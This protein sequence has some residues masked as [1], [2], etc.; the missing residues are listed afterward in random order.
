MAETEE[1]AH[2]PLYDW[3]AAN[4]AKFVPFAGYNM[5]VQYTLGVMKEHLWTRTEAGLFDVS[6]MG[7]VRL[8]GPDHETLAQFLEGLTPTDLQ[9]LEAGRQRYCLLLNDAGGIIDDLMVARPRLRP[10]TSTGGGELLLV[11]NAGRKAVDIAHLNQHLPANCKLDVL[12]HGL[13]ALQGPRTPD[14]LAGLVPAA[15]E[16]RFMDAAWFNADG[17]EVHITRSGYTGE[18]GFEILCAARDAPG[19]W[20][21]LISDDRVEAIG[22]GARDSL[23]MEAGMPLYGNDIDE[24]T[25]PVEAGLA[26]AVGKSRRQGGTREG[27]FPGAERI[28]H[29]LANGTQ[30]HRVGLVGEGRAPMREGTRVFANESDNEPVGAVTSGCFG[31]SVEAAISM[32][33]LPTQLIADGTRVFAEVR[34][35]RRP[36]RV[37]KLPFYRPRYQ[38]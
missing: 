19:L 25:T 5:P 38:R 21:H 36:A 30:C 31:P 1:L 33:R 29:E 23:R 22:L 34:G 4:G 35:K 7:P 11:L 13:I 17:R 15:Q 32:A 8:T 37:A 27:G 24:Q 14:V 3:H 12:G 6:H 18:D 16:L 2:T 28:L 20:E 10:G 26:W 9:G